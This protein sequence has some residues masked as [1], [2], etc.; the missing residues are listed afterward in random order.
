MRSDAPRRGVGLRGLS[1]SAFLAGT[2]QHGAPGSHRFHSWQRCPQAHLAP[3]A[4]LVQF[5]LLAAAVC[6]GGFPLVRGI[7]GTVAD[8]PDAGRS[9][10]GDVEESGVEDRACAGDRRRIGAVSTARLRAPSSTAAAPANGPGHARSALSALRR[11]FPGS[12]GG[13]RNP[14]SAGWKSG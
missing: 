7:F 9:G 2:G 13:C 8:R 1:H 11:V 6:R 12:G 4:R 10:Q 14:S 5:S 3:R